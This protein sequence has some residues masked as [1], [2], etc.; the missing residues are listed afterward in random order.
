[1]E[2]I[3][4]GGIAVAAFASG[5]FFFRFWRQTRDR[6]FLFFALAFWIEAGHRLVIYQLVG[7]EASPVHYLPRLLGYGLIVYAI[8]D[9]NRAAKPPARE[10]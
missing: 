3:L 2:G 5:L 4:V 6:F 10:D 1:M 7:P 9:K 8:F